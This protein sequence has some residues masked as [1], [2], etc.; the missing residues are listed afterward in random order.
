MTI[1]LVKKA[2]QLRRPTL[3]LLATGVVS[4]W[5]GVVGLPAISTTQ[6]PLTQQAAIAQSSDVSDEE[7]AQYAQAA[8]A[9]DRYRNTAYTEIK[10]ILLTVQMDISD[11]DVSC[12]DTQ[13][14]SEVPR[15][16]RRDVREIL[17]RY[18][19]QSSTA[20][21]DAGLTA[22]RFN[23]ITTVHQSD[24]TVFERIQQALLRLQE[25]Q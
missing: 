18:C 8:L 3:K 25:A 6:W 22:R 24:T 11:I 9:I 17:T 21:E 7:I 16:V 15:S 12:T 14:L 10:D 2:W 1:I 4:G 13:D 20:V 23:E 19:N 5:L